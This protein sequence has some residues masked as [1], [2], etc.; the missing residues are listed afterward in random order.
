MR[1]FSRLL[2][3]ASRTL[4]AAEPSFKNSEAVRKGQAAK[5]S[6]TTLNAI[7]DAVVVVVGLGAAYE[8]FAKAASA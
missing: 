2:H 4:R 7:G 8:V 5:S 3:T 1:T 6:K